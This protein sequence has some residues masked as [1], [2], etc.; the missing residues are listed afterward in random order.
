MTIWEFIG[1]ATLFIIAVNVIWLIVI[2]A[3]DYLKGEGDE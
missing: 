2:C 1:T 3:K